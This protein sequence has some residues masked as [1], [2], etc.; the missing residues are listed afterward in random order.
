M[1]EEQRKN[2]FLDEYSDLL[3]E[4]QDSFKRCTHQQHQEQLLRFMHNLKGASRE[5]EFDEL[6]N[7]AGQLE[8]LMAKIKHKK[9]EITSAVAYLLQEAN[10][11]L[12]NYLTNIQLNRDTT[13]GAQDLQNK[14][15]LLLKSSIRQ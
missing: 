15:T 1:I 5:M 4:I 7:L 10:T 6:S 13:L 8:Q 12:T 2:R 14:I 9:I 11:L 3:A